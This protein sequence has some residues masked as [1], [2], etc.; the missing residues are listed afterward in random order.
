MSHC[1]CPHHCQHQ[2]WP[3]QC[4]HHCW[5]QHQPHHHHHRHRTIAPA[6]QQSS[7]LLF[8]LSE[9]GIQPLHKQLSLK[10]SSLDQAH[11]SA[12]ASSALPNA[13]RLEEQC[14]IP[15]SHRQFSWLVNANAQKVML[16]IQTFSSSIFF[17][18]SW[19]WCLSGT[20]TGCA[21]KMHGAKTE[22]PI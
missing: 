9:P 17:S 11:S 15:H 22:I 5:H 3:L 19:F 21:L 8:D 12:H 6:R 16:G 2:G 1:H 7:W 18:N 20:G 4:Q 13:P 10:I 14:R